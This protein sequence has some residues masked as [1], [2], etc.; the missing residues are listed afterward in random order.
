MWHQLM[1]QKFTNT[2]Q[3]IIASTFS[4]LKDLW[5]YENLPFMKMVFEI[6]Y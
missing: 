1:W 4:A 5:S 3:D 6:F 2:S